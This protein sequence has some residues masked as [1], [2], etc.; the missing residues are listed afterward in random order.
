VLPAAVPAASRRQSTHLWAAQHDLV[1]AIAGVPLHGHVVGCVRDGGVLR[2]GGGLGG[3]V[4][5][6]E[7][8]GGGDVASVCRTSRPT[9]CAVQLRQ[10]A[11]VF[12]S[13]KRQRFKAATAARGPRRVPTTALTRDSLAATT[14]THVHTAAATATPPPPRSKPSSQRAAANGTPADALPRG[15][16]RLQA[17]VEAYRRV[18][19]GVF[20]G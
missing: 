2:S 13:S 14:T 20:G 1:H 10:G 9:T 5:C 3:A 6:G 8:V 16:H 18:V 19:L 15:V 7:M 4:A 12:W 17:A 11:S